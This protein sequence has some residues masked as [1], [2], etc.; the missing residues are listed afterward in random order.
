MSLRQTLQIKESLEDLLI[1]KKKQNNYKALQKLQLL[2]LIKENPT[3]LRSETAKT[4]QISTRT[5]ERWLKI[6]QEG[7]VEKLVAKRKSSKKSAIITDEIHQGLLKKVNSTSGCFLGYWDAQ[8]WVKA[9]YNVDVTY[10]NLR[11]Y[12]I[13]HFKTK[14]KKPRKSHYKKDQ[15]AYEAFLKNPH[16]IQVD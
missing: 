2:E 4:I 10:F 14:L 13:K 5:Q 15:Q 9:T 11:A 16:N 8:Q 7:G 6:Y 3:L 1:L 12:M